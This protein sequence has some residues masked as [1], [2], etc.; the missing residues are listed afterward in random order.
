MK[1]VYETPEVEKIAFQYRDQVVVASGSYDKSPN[2]DPLSTG[3]CKYVDA[4]WLRSEYSGTQ[5][6]Q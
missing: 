2:H 1:K 5:C 6:S 3:E 4:E